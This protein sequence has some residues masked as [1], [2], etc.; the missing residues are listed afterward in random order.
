MAR[1]LIKKCQIRRKILKYYNFILLDLDGVIFNSKIIRGYHGIYVEKF[2]INQSFDQYFMYLGLPI[3]D[4][5]KNLKI[6]S[7][8][9]KYYKLLSETLK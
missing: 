1:K 5:L 4:I 7:N 6:K 2:N 9:K 3:N 8:F